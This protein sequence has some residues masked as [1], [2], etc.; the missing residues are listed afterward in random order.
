MC[1]RYVSTYPCSHTRSRWELCSKAKAGNLL[2]LGKPG[3][4]CEDSVRKNE[5]PDLQDSCGSTC[6]TRPYKCNNCDSEKKQ[7]GWR[8]VDCNGMWNSSVLTWM[9]C[10]CPKHP[11]PETILGAA[12]CVACL[13]AC[14]PKGPK[15]DWRCHGCKS[16]NQTYPSE[17]EC[18][19]C[20][21]TRCGECNSPET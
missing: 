18:K 15:I 17:M 3:F 9:P 2:R 13:N 6:L 10:Q 19:K 11:C 16:F 5:A 4:H 21:H 12:F 7:L 8:C 1:I 14:V 20:L